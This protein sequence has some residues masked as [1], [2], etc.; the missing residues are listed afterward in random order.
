VARG[1]VLVQKKTRGRRSAGRS[2][3]VSRSVV[4]R[5]SVPSVVVTPL[6]LSLCLCVVV[7]VLRA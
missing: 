5:A 1:V 6:S 7:V 3:A 2:I 4:Q